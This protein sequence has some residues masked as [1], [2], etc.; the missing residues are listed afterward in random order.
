MPPSYYLFLYISNAESASASGEICFS[1]KND[2][3]GVFQ[4]PLSATR[5]LL[6]T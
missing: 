1:F 4:T 2:V 3:R 6:G 5:V